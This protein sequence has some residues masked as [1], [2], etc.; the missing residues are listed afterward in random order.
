MSDVQVYTV[1]AIYGGVFLLVILGM[2][3]YEKKGKR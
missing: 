2:V 3:S 1:L